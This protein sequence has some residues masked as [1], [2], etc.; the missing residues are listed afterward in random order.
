M[1]LH[2]RKA[3][4]L[5]LITVLLLSLFSYSSSFAAHEKISAELAKEIKSG[6]NYLIPVIVQAKY[7]LKEKH[8]NWIHRSGGRLKHDL[9]LIKSFSADL[10][11]S[12]IEEMVAD[13][14][15]IQICYDTEVHAC[16]DT[17]VPAVNAPAAWEAGY[18]GKG[19]TVAVIDTGIYPHPDL[20]EPAN[21]IIAFKDFINRKTAPYDD[22]GH[23]THVAGIIAGNGNKSNGQYIGVAPE[24]SLVGVKV[25]DSTGSG[26]SSD[27]IAG[28]QWVVQNKVIYNIQ[29]MNLSLGAQASQSYTI[30]PLSLAAQEA[31]DAGLI[32]VSA[33]GN[34]GPAE[35]TINTPGINP[36]IITVGA[37][38]DRG[39]VDIRDD[40]I[41]GFSS[42]GPTIDGLTKPDLLAPGVGITSLAADT[43]YL[44]KKNS[45]PKAK[46]DKPAKAQSQVQPV[47]TTISDYY[48]TMSGTSMATP[49]VAGTAALLLEGNPALTPDEVKG[50]LMSNAVDLGFAPNEQGAGNLRYILRIN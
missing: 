50:Q 13:E 49:M 31:W 11:S 41:A 4:T 32:V 10:P 18:T 42:R 9:S 48:I 24:A 44:P 5:I 46:P 12:A 47:Q 33:A 19:I 22:C 14:D 3:I 36:H 38:D 30:D 17:A 23:G 29:V 45:G 20:T 21:R 34:N 7:G 28:I 37:A 25:L 43:S 27:V 35:G 40:V 2:F 16:L 1:K 15:T 6:S 26:R 8:K 39:T